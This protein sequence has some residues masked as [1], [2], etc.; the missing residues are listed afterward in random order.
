MTV[1]KIAI[2]GLTILLLGSL[3]LAPACQTSHCPSEKNPRVHYV[4]TDPDE[5]AV[6]RFYCDPGQEP[7][8]NECG[9]GCIDQK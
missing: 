8:S 4:S 9:C 6:I 1:T 5:C 2:L 3:L 7:F